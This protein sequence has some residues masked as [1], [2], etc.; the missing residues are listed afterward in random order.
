[1]KKLKFVDVKYKFLGDSED[2]PKIKY[3]CL[4]IDNRGEGVLVV[5]KLWSFFLSLTDKEKKDY[6]L[7]WFNNGGCRG[8]FRKLIE[9]VGAEIRKNNF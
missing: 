2:F 9:D 7:K 1:M 8:F 4:F 5:V 3:S 6:L